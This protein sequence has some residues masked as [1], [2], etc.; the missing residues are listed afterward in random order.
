M[1]T[2]YSL[3]WQPLPTASACLH[4]QPVLIA[5]PPAGH[6]TL[7]YL[8]LLPLASL[9]RLP[10]LLAPWPDLPL[11]HPHPHGDSRCCRNTAP[12]AWPTHNTV[13]AATILIFR[14]SFEGVL[15]PGQG[16]FLAG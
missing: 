1:P 11:A 6:A 16:F 7:Y 15:S 8:P 12:K 2:C 10:F 5:R 9:A 4:S 3:L 14:A 13:P